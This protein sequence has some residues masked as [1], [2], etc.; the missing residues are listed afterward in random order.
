VTVLR[1]RFEHQIKWSLGS[2]PKSAEAT[3]GH[4]YLTQSTLARLR[5]KRWAIACKRYRHAD[6]RRC[7]VHHS[8]DGIQIV[9]N[10]VV[11]KRLD[12]YHRPIVLQRTP[13]GQTIAVPALRNS[14][15]LR[16]DRIAVVI[17]NASLM[18]LIAACVD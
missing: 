15:G 1:A 12:D 18:G 4:H 16:V 11:R 6:L 14:L 2:A 8:A 7:S 5:A 13:S 10:I 9:L 17:S 3:T